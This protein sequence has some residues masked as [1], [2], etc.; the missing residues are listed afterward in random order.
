MV[1]IS[2]DADA[3]ADIRPITNIQYTIDLKLL[4]LN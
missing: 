4:Y 3:D 1:Q 2:A